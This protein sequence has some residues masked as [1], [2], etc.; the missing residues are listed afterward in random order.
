[1]SFPKTETYKGTIYRAAIDYQFSK[2]NQRQ[3]GKVER[4]NVES[5]N[6]KL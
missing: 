6:K 4:Q 1:M 2:Y 5:I 3:E